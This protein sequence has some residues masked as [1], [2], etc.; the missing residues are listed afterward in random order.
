M[1][2]RLLSLFA[3]L[4]LGALAYAPASAQAIPG[5]SY[6]QS[7]TNVVVRGDRLSA[8]C[9]GSQ[10]SS[11]RSSISLRRCQGTD[12]ANVNGRLSCNGSTYSGNGNDGYG[13]NGKHA[14]RRHHRDGDDRSNGDGNGGYNNGYG[15]GG[16]DNGYGN[17]RYG[18]TATNGSYLQS[19]SNV[20]TRGGMI[21]ATCPSA[22]GT[23]ITSTINAA[24]C[25]GGDI[26]NVNG[27]LQCR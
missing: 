5:G 7:C 21:T 2:R 11:M 19:C 24:R 15:N 22:N 6:Q 10:G 27:R 25:N 13:N 1:S 17:Q 18:T 4:G 9:N 16:R 12:I 20:Q 3:I 23:Q 14:H 8:V 26:A